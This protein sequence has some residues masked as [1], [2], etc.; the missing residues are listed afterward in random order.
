[1]KR[2]AGNVYAEQLRVLNRYYHAL[3]TRLAEEIREKQTDF[4]NP[5]LGEAESLLEKHA[6]ALADFW[7]VYRAPEP[8]GEMLFQ[9]RLVSLQRGQYLC[10]RCRKIVRKK[11]GTCP[12][13][14]WSWEKGAS[15]RSL[16]SGGRVTEP[17]QRALQAASEH[18]RQLGWPVVEPE[19]LLLALAEEGRGVAAKALADAGIDFATLAS[20]LPPR[21]P[22]GLRGGRTALSNGTEQVLEDAWAESRQRASKNYLNTGHLL[23]AIT[24]A[25]GGDTGAACPVCCRSTWKHYAARLRCSSTLKFS[26]RT[27]LLHA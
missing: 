14:G 18:A 27:Q 8:H 13:C 6:R 22:G 11:D 21:G 17:A 2:P 25:H 16:P 15:R 26:D 23:L 24:R 20:R 7:T 12:R 4:A 1:M 9:R 10:F 3:I 19:H 5:L